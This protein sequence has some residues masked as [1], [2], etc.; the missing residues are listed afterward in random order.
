[1][2]CTQPACKSRD[3]IRS[4]AQ[5]GGGVRLISGLLPT[6]GLPSPLELDRIANSVL[7]FLVDE[8]LTLREAAA[9]VLRLRDRCSLRYGDIV[10]FELE[11]DI[12][13]RIGLDATTS[14]DRIVA[15]RSD[16][17][18][19]IIARDGV[20]LTESDLCQTGKLDNETRE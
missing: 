1:V 12:V 6:V 3:T 19:G 8:V 7:R 20:L 10:A 11:C 17:Q 16:H 18:R 14:D 2:R 15:L 4:A 13:L 9:V 5:T